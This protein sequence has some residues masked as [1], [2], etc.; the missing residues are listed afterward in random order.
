MNARLRHSPHLRRVGTVLLL[1]L[2]ATANAA[3]PTLTLQLDSTVALTEPLPFTVVVTNRTTAALTVEDPRASTHAT[4][5]LVDVQTKEDH[6][7]SM[8]QTTTTNLGQDQWALAVPVVKPVTLNAADSLQ[9][10]A[11]ANERL[12]LRP[13]TFDVFFSLDDAQSNHVTLTVRFTPKSVER[14]LGLAAD[15]NA[16]Y[17]RREWAVESLKRLK[18]D[19]TLTLPLPDAT[20][21]QRAPLEAAN[22]EAVRSLRQWVASRPPAEL[23][24]QLAAITR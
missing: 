24:K 7:F 14:L 8:G 18:P 12:F 3:V 13:G 5:H 17:A 15:A 11:D 9:V 20:P 16:S 2:A 4:L 21:K 1:M 6:A 10:R 22:R 19:F 23:T